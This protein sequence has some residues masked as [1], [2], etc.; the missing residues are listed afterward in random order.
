MI[1][2]EL[3]QAEKSRIEKALL[4]PATTDD[5]Y[6]QLYA[7]QQAISWIAD[8]EIAASPYDVI[9]G[10]KVQPLVKDTLVD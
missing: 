6:C 10:G 8:K 3:M 7:A 5:M 1:N 9:M 4:D 2:E